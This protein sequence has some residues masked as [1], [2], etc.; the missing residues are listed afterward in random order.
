VKRAR[1][2]AA[3]IFGTIAAI[4]VYA[5]AMWYS[6]PDV[7]VPPL[8]VAAVSAHEWVL[9]NDYQTAQSGYT[10]R[11]KAGFRTDFASI[12]SILSPRLGLTPDSACLRR[13]A[14]IHD[15]CY[16]ARLTDKDAAD[17]LLRDAV[18]ADGCEP[19]KAAAVWQAV[20]D[21]GFTAW[22]AKTP[23]S[24]REARGLVRVS[25]SE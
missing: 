20:H 15:G 22:D 6:Q 16:A 2:W 24:I 7:Q 9:T 3:G 19:H 11:F 21:F 25:R 4:G 8:P 14:L 17:E 12:P 10:F 13:G 5:G 18:E 1:K 23:D